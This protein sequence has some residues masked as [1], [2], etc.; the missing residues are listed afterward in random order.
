MHSHTFDHIIGKVLEAENIE[1]REQYKR[2]EQELLAAK[3]QLE[4]VQETHKQQLKS[5][6]DKMRKIMDGKQRELTTL[7]EQL[8]SQDEKY[9]EIEQVLKELTS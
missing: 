6:D 3:H 5:I 9:R 1:V 8:R 7:K 2:I 4:E